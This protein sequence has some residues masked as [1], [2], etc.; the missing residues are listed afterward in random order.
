MAGIAE[1][2]QLA[3]QL[4][5]THI[6]S[7]KVDLGNETLSNTDYLKQIFEAEVQA[8]ESE[9]LDRRRKA[10]N[11]PHRVFT[12][13]K[14]NKG[15]KW[16]IEQLEQ[17]DW[18]EASEDIA[19]IGRCDTGKTSL[20]VHLGELALKGGYRVYYCN[21]DVF[22]Q[23]LRHKDTVDKYHRKF[24]YMIICDLIIIDELMYVALS[25]QD[26]PLFYRAVNFLKEERSI[27]Y[28]TNR[29]LSEW[30]QVADDKHLMETLTQKIMSSSQQIRLQ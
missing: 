13:G 17:L 28:I 12:T 30:P 19:I 22:L 10:S 14:L 25:E 11:L 20:A 26:L 4:G 2:Q 5:I 29:E 24:R 7:G 8:R 16:Q 27:I 23:I 6:A 15:V 1:L 18:I 3:Q 21:I 9:A